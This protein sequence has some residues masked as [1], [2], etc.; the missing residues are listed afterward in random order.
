M[1]LTIQR[2]A[3]CRANYH[4]QA[5]GIGAEP[6]NHKEYCPDC[7][8]AIKK[9]LQSVPVRFKF[10]FVPQ[11]DVTLEQ[12]ESWEQEWR[13]E[14]KGM[15]PLARRVFASSYDPVLKECSRYGIVK[16]RGEHTGKVF[17]YH[18]WP[19][20]RHQA[21]VGIGMEVNMGTGEQRVCEE[22]YNT[23]GGCYG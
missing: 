21:K 1:R 6:D 19:S 23:M 11:T 13:D 12:V 2:C 10:V 3:H 7:W 9:S 18:Y 15:L 22:F 16:G 17:N 5:S 4:F 14:H 8:G 20:S